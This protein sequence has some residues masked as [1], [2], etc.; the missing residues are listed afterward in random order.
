MLGY[1]RLFLT[2]IVLF[3]HTVILPNSFAESCISSFFLISGFGMSLTLES[4]YKNQPL[5]FY[6]NRIVRL[7]PLHILVTAIVLYLCATGWS[8]YVK[9]GFSLNQIIGSFL[10][11]PNMPSFNNPAWTL[12]YE[13]VFYLYVPLVMLHPAFRWIGLA[14][15][16]FLLALYGKS[17]LLV[18][19]FSFQT[20]SH[21]NAAFLF[22]L[23]MCLF[24][25]NQK[26]I[27][28]QHPAWVFI[29]P[30]ALLSFGILIALLSLHGIFYNGLTKFDRHFYQIGYLLISTIT[31]I[32]LISWNQDESKKST[33]AGDLCYPMY[34]FHHPI[35]AIFVRHPE[36]YDFLKSIKS[37]LP[38][39][40][41]TLFALQTLATLIPTIIL[42]VLWLKI[43][44]HTFR[45]WRWRGKDRTTTHVSATGTPEP[46]HR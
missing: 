6:W 10:L 1:L 4:N 21:L 19:P 35:F 28:K 26:T 40:E 24:T 43:E 27:S 25:I 18:L 23:G 22:F 46:S 11:L 14:G 5:P 32:V 15:S 34:L 12:S 42:S 16:V 29:A 44:K 30:R 38:G 41:F 20:K 36:F 17:E 33:Y 39:K 31:I 9:S 37:F 7:Y 13:I 45:K 8:D 2:T 3:R